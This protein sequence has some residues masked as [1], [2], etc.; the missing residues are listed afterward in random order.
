LSNA[1]SLRSII[2]IRYPING[3]LLASRHRTDDTRRVLII[4]TTECLLAILN[5]WLIDIILSMK[6]CHRSVVIGDDCPYF[7]RRS[8]QFLTC[9]DLFNSMSNICLYSF[10][11]Q[12]FRSELRRMFKHWLYVLRHCLPIDCHEQRRT[13]PTI[14]LNVYNE[15]VLVSSDTSTKP[16]KISTRQIEQV[17]EYIELRPVTSPT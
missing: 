15:R 10:A 13:K 14:Q 12:R 8:H 5:S 4:I 2:N 7:L 1:L 9:F 3:Q 6:Y 11:G 17:Y 16:T